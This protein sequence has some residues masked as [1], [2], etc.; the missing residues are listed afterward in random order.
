MAFSRPGRSDVR[1]TLSS[2]TSG[3]ASLI[4]PPVNPARVRSSGARNAF[5]IASEI[6]SPRRTSRSFRRRTC[7]LDKR[8]CVVD[9]RHGLAEP[10][11]PVVAGDLLDHVDL[12][13]AVRSP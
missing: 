13:L 3:L 1:N 6:P 9:L 2:A 4:A 12:G 5:G 8:P 11:V 7:L 10:V